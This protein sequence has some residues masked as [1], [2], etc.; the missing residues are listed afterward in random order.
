MVKGFEYRKGE[1]VVI[2][3]EDLKKIA[4]ATAKSMDI[5]QF[6]KTDEVDP[7][8]FDKSY[9]M[10]PEEAVSKPYALLLKAMAETEYVA[11]AKIAMH[12]REHVAI[13]RPTADG[14]VLH[15]MYFVDELHK[16]RVGG[17]NAKNQFAAKEMDLAK[18][19]IDTL[20]SP[21]KPEAYEDE[22]K[23]NVERL[24]EQKR[25]G[26]TVTAVSQPKVQPVTDIM[27]ALK[28]SLE[29]R[30]SSKHTAKKTTHK[31]KAA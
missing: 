4:P 21:F 24:I 2:E 25:K 7:I 26:K 16:A 9:Y 19:L 28:R 13:I 29:S 15:T 5:L 1:Y 14:L 30:A 10:A 22:Y 8:F 20:A 31:R 18:R 6:V 23:K 27:E 3:D 12:A 11:V 17:K